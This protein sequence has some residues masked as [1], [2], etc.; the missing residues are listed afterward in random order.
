MAT[1]QRKKSPARVKSCASGK[2][3]HKKAKRAQ[4][5]KKGL[6]DKVLKFIGL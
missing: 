6:F 4:R 5:S 1:K 3:Y 2:T